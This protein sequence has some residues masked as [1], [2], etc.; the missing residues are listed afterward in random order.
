[1]LL[2]IGMA[3]PTLVSALLVIMMYREQLCS[4]AAAVGMVTPS[5][6]PHYTIPSKPQPL[7]NG[8]KGNFKAYFDALPTDSEFELSDSEQK[9]LVEADK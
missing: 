5:H 9:H 6:K 8:T 3:I 1:M 2:V 7:G 4:V